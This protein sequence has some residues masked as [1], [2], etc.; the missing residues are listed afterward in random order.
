MSDSDVSAAG[1]FTDDDYLNHLNSQ[2]EAKIETL[3]AEV[4]ELKAILEN[5]IIGNENDF[6]AASDAY[7]HIGEILEV[8]D[9]GSVCGTVELMIAKVKELEA[10]SIKNIVAFIIC[11]NCNKEYE[12]KFGYFGNS[13]GGQDASCN[14][15]NCDHCGDRNDPWL[16]LT[17]TN[18]G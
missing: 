11:G 10:N 12:L 16:K 6:V 3:D 17:T 15:Q 8:P 4:K 9:G 18:K 2:L 7:Y 14:F 5:R 1:N 13:S